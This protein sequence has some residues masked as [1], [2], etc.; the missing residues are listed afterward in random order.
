LKAFNQAKIP[1][2]TLKG[3]MLSYELYKDVGLRQ[4]KDLD[5]A[6][7]P[8]DINRAQ[9][10]LNDLGWRLDSTYFPMTPRQWERLWRTEQH[11]GFVDSQAGTAL[12]LHWRNVWDLPGMNSARWARSIQSVWQGR[13]YQAMNP[14]DEV[15]YL[16]CHGAEHAW[17]RAKWLGDLARIHAAGLVSWE[18]ALERAQNTHQDKP[19]LSCLQILKAVYGLPLPE[20]QRSPW[21]NLSSFLID[22]PLYS[23]KISKDPAASAA[24]NL[25]P[26][27][28]RLML[29]ER[30]VL[31]RRSWRESL[32]ELAYCR[33]DF[34]VLRLPDSIF[35]AYVPLRPILWGWRKLSRVW[36][37]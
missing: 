12:E 25:L 33:E 29:Y 24:L 18:A 36:A 6:V 1:V 27:R 32:S 30:Q 22:S 19:L 7:A 23:L 4:S 9:N 3:P 37:R 17:F 5:L 8:D 13:S 31:P 26:G 14:I 35:W 28:V 34:E 10:C 2:M 21:E 20:L 15:L 16:C 11:L